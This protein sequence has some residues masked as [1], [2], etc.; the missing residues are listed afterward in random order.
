MKTKKRLDGKLL[1]TT[2]CGVA[3]MA[4]ALCA[5]FAAHATTYYWTYNGEGNF[6]DATKWHNGHDTGA[7]GTVPGPDDKARISAS[8][9]GCTI[10][11]NG[12]YQIDELFVDGAAQAGVTNSHTLAG[13]GTLRLVH[14]TGGETTMTISTGASLTLDGPNLY[15]SNGVQ[16]CEGGTFVVKSG[17]YTP[18]TH[19]I[20]TYPG[21]LVIDGG[22]V[23]SFDAEY[24]M[25]RNERRIY[26]QNGWSSTGA[27][28]GF[29]DLKSGLLDA[30][31]TFC[32][33][34]FTMTG[35]T[36]DRS[37]T[38]HSKYMPQLMNTENLTV[39]ILG[40]ER[41]VLHNSDVVTNDTSLLVVDDFFA[42]CNQSW[43]PFSEDA[44]YAFGSLQ[45]PN[46]TLYITNNVTLTGRMLAFKDCMFREGAND[47]VLNVE[48]IRV[49]KA[50]T[51]T[52]VDTASPRPLHIYSPK[53]V[54][55]ESASGNL[56]QILPS[57]NTNVYWRIGEGI[58]V[59]TTAEDGS[60]PV[61]IM[62]GNPLFDEGA[63]ADF[64]GAGDVEIKFSNYI[65]DGR[66]V[67]SGF[68][69]QLARISM[70]G[71][72]ML[73]MNNWSWNASDF[74]FQ[75]ERFILG[76]GSKLKTTAATYSHFDANEVEM[77]ASN[78]L[79]ILTPDMTD[80]YGFPPAALMTG[81]K[82][83][84]DFQTAATRPTVTLATSGAG[85][86]W[87]A[88]WING[89]PVVWRKDLSQRAECKITRTKMSQWR[90]TVDGDW[91]N[92]A[93]WFVDTDAGKEQAA[94]PLEQAMVFDGGYT[95]TRVTVSGTAK[96]Y[97][98]RVYN[99]TAPVAF[100]G[101][102][103]IELGSNDRTII[104]ATAA[105]VNAAIVNTSE[106]PVVFD[107]PVGISDSL[108]SSDR[109]LTVNQASRAYVAFM[110]DFDGGIAAT[111]KGD[112][113]IGG[114]ASAENIQLTDQ[115]SGFPAKRTRLSVIPGGRVT[116]TKPTTL[117]GGA[118]CEIVIYSN[119][120]FTANNSS[121]EC[122]WG[123]DA[124]RRPIWVKEFGR[125]DSRAPLGGSAK[126][127]FKGKGEVR[128]A[129]TGS[130]ATAD[131]PVVFDGV[132]FA[133]DAFTAGHPIELKGSP[134]WAAKTDWTYALGALA[135][136]AGETLTVDTGD[137]DTGA[138]HS[139]A[140]N[141]SLA[142]DK[143]VKTGD[144]TLTLGS[145]ANAIGDV[146]VA[147]GTLA[148][149][150]SQTF[151]S[152][153]MSPST[154]LR[155]AAAGVTV[156]VADSLDIADVTLA[157]DG[158]ARSAIGNVWTTVL[159]IPAG[160]ALTGVPVPADKMYDVRIVEEAGSFVV[161]ARVKSGFSIIFR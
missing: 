160:S 86:A 63:T 58:D 75:A 103:A 4:V 159:T 107:V 45:V 99:K 7:T 89:Q 157:L 55:L 131:Y 124:E 78:E 149:A 134:T 113:R 9:A 142:A 82:H 85:D 72:G 133:V 108:A 136:P 143:L 3:A 139:V 67:Q 12:D 17:T 123:N 36:W 44:D 31:C 148:L 8:C 92:S 2:S 54:R 144:G 155:I 150:A 158:A 132:T 152:F 48:T 30:S 111:F 87:E 97:Q 115:S 39:S 18:C 56:T 125:F 118:N 98:I 61:D 59:S 161:Q 112:V 90:G 146:Q 129:D 76:T 65:G 38:S 141:S 94:N 77:D 46:A 138:G 156:A 34:T 88:K 83:V 21:R 71:G 127:S 27:P 23:T 1:S 74:P 28:V 29:I 101:E 119:A 20:K 95:N 11:V 154:T 14:L 73:T 69:N 70:I 13:N 68:S 16:Y 151:T 117:T 121:A 126:V 51:T 128:L 100:V 110:K 91:A 52:I 109:Y 96:A 60:T 24:G 53:R 116:A 22:T 80:K 5:V 15:A 106:N 145:S 41:L 35:G 114:T 104:G 43:Y 6:N 66:N 32:V 26:I 47:V 84:N 19:Y 33:G 10:V 93:N 81:P 120:T 40:G 62:L 105:D 49:C 135:L 25:Y 42:G 130:R 64:N 50:G 102:G 147:T 122:F 137:L 79:R 140:I 57:I 153:T 37:K